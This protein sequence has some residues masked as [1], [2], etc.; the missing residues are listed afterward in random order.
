MDYFQTAAA[1]RAETTMVCI[2]KKGK[3]H[4]HLMKHIYRDTLQVLANYECIFKS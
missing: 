4:L 1:P 3:A 2:K